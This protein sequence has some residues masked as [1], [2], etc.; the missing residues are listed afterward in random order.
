MAGLPKEKIS[1]LK[2]KWAFGVPGATGMFAQ[3]TVV[4]GRVF[5][6]SQH[7]TVYSLD[8]SSRARFSKPGYMVVCS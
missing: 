3:P 8:A 4:G 1:S 6:G 5:F 7:G 2:L